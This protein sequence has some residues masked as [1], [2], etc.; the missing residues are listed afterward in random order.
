MYLDKVLKPK[1]TIVMPI[2]NVEQWLEEAILSVINQVDIS[3]ENDVEI[4]LMNDC[5]PDNSSEICIKYAKLYPNNIYYHV[6]PEN[7]KL[8]ETRN[9]GLKIARGKYVNF[10]DPDDVLSKNV[11][12]EVF[13]FYENL[14]DEVSHVSIPLIYFEAATGLH[15]KYINLGHK[16]RVINLEDEPYNFILSSASSFYVTSKVKDKKFDTTLFGE[17]DT[18]FNFN[19]YT[20]C[21]KVGYVVE[22]SVCYN[23][24]RRKE[25]GSQ[26][27][28]SL[29]KEEAYQTP[30]DLL[31]MIDICK[32]S[33]LYYELVVYQLRSRLKSIHPGIF[34][35]IDTYNQILSSY[36]NLLK[37]LPKKFIIE[38]SKFLDVDLKIL[39]ITECYQ[40]PISLNDEG[41]LV[42]QNQEIFKC[43]DLFIDVRRIEVNNGKITVEVLFNDYGLKDLDLVLYKNKTKVVKPVVSYNTD[44]VYIKKIGN[45]KSSD[46]IKYYKFEINECDVGEYLV[47]FIN[48]KNGYL[49]VC[50]K[51]RTYLGNPFLPN[52][53]FNSKFFKLYTKSNTAVYMFNKK[54]VVEKSNSIHK[55]KNKIKSFVLI[56]NKHNSFK[57]LRLTKLNQPKYWLFNDRPIN[58][59]D[60]AEALFSYINSEEKELARKC[61]FVL[62]ANSPDFDR[63]KKIGKVV[64][65]NSIKHKFLYLNSEFV[66]TSHLATS[67]FQPIKHG[68]SK[69]YNDL[70]ES[71]IIWLQHGITMNDI[72]TAANKFHKNV[73]KVVTSAN[74]EKD[75]FLSH[76]YFYN[77]DDILD[78]GFTRHD[79]LILNESEQ[80]K[81]ILIMPTWRSYL[82]GKILSTGL[83][84]KSENFENS[85]YYKRF[86]SLLMNEDFLDLID[87]KGF[88]VKFVLHPGFKMYGDLFQKCESKRVEVIN[89]ISVSYSD[90]LKKSSILVTDYSSVF[91]D[92]SYMKKPCLFFQFDQNDF[93]NN[94]YKKGVFDFETM[95]PGPIF[96]E[97]DE[98]VEYI[99]FLIDNDCKVEVD[100]LERISSIFKYTDT[101]N[102]KRL[103]EKVLKNVN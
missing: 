60:N 7:L 19:M 52:S 50:N 22:R 70:I 58:A 72:E 101:K 69:Y 51:I 80:E 95:A 56:K 8:S 34:E 15:P 98:L 11:L 86:S 29:I 33:S 81:V 30:I 92:F 63:I 61:Y 84:A 71:K 46:E 40:K 88:T 79:N 24:R 43:N 55:I 16:N 28:L 91:F 12:S 93:Y 17:E 62:S 4:L 82:S 75:I 41:V 65:Q 21:K 83:H 100:Y 25:G 35:N 13:K 87:K 23:Y 77:T 39:F 54:I 20:D 37:Q 44:S 96:N 31:S 90:L 9:R 49:H 2:Y 45:F 74:Y 6:N 67:F 76:K 47:Y 97:L 64:V 10:L 73:A 1:F 14:V 89:Q 26:V 5:S 53:V 66:F 42:C 48:K 3:F 85:E 18:L 36:I 57:W 103:L 27:N 59:N 99:D 68:F 78:T 94:H 32:E 102:S 38:E